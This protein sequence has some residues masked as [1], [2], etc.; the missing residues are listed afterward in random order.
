M[1]GCALLPPV[2]SAPFYFSLCY[3][4][5]IL[6]NYVYTNSSDY[7]LYIMYF[8]LYII[9]LSYTSFFASSFASG[10]NPSR[11]ALLHFPKLCFV[12]SQTHLLVVLGSLGRGSPP[13]QPVAPLCVHDSVWEPSSEGMF[14]WGA[15][16]GRPGVPL[17]SPGLQPPTLPT[18]SLIPCSGSAQGGHAWVRISHKGLL[19]HPEARDVSFVFPGPGWDFYCTF[20]WRSCPSKIPEFEGVSTPGLCPISGIVQTGLAWARHRLKRLC[21]VRAFPDLTIS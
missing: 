5:I 14:S 7:V 15:V 16:A 11:C 13:P 19:F 6:Y 9:Y 2:M 12:L 21:S 10:W 18:A 20:S 4:L 17:S 1:P 3:K 8:T